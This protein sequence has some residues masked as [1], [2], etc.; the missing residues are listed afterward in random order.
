MVGFLVVALGVL[1]DSEKLVDERNREE[2]KRLQ[3]TWK[4]VACECAGKPAPLS[5]SP[6][7]QFVFAGTR[8]ILTTSDVKSEGVCALDLTRT[9]HTFESWIQ[10]T[11]IQHGWRDLWRKSVVYGAR[12]TWRG[13]YQLEGDTLT[14][15]T[16]PDTTGVEPPTDFFT[17]PDDYGRVVMSLK[18]QKR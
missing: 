3:G 10:R 6:H 12:E 14:I 11:E 15:C 2:M 4:A 13:V 7:E 16:M 9:P 18:H 5:K 17:K 1:E 8:I